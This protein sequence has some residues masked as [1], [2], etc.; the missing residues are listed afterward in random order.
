[1]AEQLHIPLLGQLP[2]VQSVCEAGDAGEPIAAQSDQVMSHYFAE[3]AT[4]VTE[5]VQ[6]RLTMAPATKRVHVSH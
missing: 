1:M 5:R 4:A 2:L 3:L 6:E